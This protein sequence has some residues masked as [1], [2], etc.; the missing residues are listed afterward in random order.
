M[1]YNVD[2]LT[3]FDEMPPERHR[4]LSAKG[5]VASGIAWRRKRAL[6]EYCTVM[7]AQALAVDCVA[8]DVREFIKWKKRERTATKQG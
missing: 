5:G 7:M 2:N 1:R 6:R 4:A 8:E 3:P